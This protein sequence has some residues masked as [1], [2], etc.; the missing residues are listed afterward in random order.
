ME[1]C[2][3]MESKRLQKLA[4]DNP[5]Y[6]NL[7]SVSCHLMGDIK[8]QLWAHRPT[9][10]FTTNRMEKNTFNLIVSFVMQWSESRRKL[11][12]SLHEA[13]NF[14]WFLKGFL[15]GFAIFHI[16]ELIW[17][18]R[19]VSWHFLQVVPRCKYTVKGFTT[20]VKFE[21]FFLESNLALSC[22]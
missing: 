18:L 21:C 5:N 14:P 12:T 22:W 16:S 19:G 7:L 8:D 2:G 6:A 9:S 13:H 10:P 11:Q 1:I 20:W 15:N 4:Q 17:L 3:L